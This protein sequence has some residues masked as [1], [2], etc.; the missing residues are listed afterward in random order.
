MADVLQ[1]KWEVLAEPEAL[2]TAVGHWLAIPTV[3]LKLHEFAL[4]TESVAAQVT[5]V[6]PIGKVLPDGGEHS[7]LLSPQGSAAPAM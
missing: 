1:A 6:M 4:P 5:V 3:I 2:A 7:K